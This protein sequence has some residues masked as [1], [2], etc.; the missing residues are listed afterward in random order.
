MKSRCMLVSASI[1]GW[2]GASI[3]LHQVEDRGGE[4]VDDPPRH[5]VVHGG[6]TEVHAAQR[7]WSVAEGR[8]PCRS[9]WVLRLS[10]RSRSFDLRFVMSRRKCARYILC[11]QIGCVHQIS[12]TVLVEG[13]G[14]VLA[15]HPPQNSPKTPKTTKT[16]KGPP[17]P[18][19]AFSPKNA[20]FQKV[21][22]QTPKTPLQTQSW[23]PTS[24]CLND[25]T[26]RI[27]FSCYLSPRPV[28]SSPGVY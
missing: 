7:W 8:Q 21:G 28:N 24:K 11:T 12:A 6:Q 1:E 16:P 15:H 23:A 2:A 19:N 20:N 25:L 10:W 27:L 5:L 17:L 14:G 4:R 9:C 13:K 22:R 18:K 3:H 26:K